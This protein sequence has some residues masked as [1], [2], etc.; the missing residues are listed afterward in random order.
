MDQRRVTRRAF[1]REG[2]QA[3][4]GVVIGSA[5]AGG[6]AAAQT[7]SAIDPAQVINYNPSMA[8]R[9]LGKTGLVLS[10]ISFG[11][12]WRNRDGG[13]Y[14]GEFAEDQVPGDVGL[15]RTE[16]MSACMEAGINYLDITTPAECLA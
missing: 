13:R 15:N 12:H 1:L 3:A 2:S 4:A 9:R 10:E 8:Y 6:R 14:W 5:L 11:G 16:V 7:E